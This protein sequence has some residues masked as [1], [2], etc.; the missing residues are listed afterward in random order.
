ML[1]IGKWLRHRAENVAALLMGVM[2]V[3]FII[4]VAARY[5]FNSPVSWADELSVIT[6]IWTILWGTAFV[7]RETDNIRFDMIYGSVTP[8]TRRI[9]DAVASIALIL[10]FGVGFP[11]AWSYVSF[12]KIESTAALHIRYDLV[13]SVYIM[14]AAAMIVRHLLILR[15]AITGHDQPAATDTPLETD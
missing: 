7:T 14:F 11:A 9:F 3:S 6:G 2:F 1:E 15:D 12:M 5:V 8:K 13:F 4:Q 10:I